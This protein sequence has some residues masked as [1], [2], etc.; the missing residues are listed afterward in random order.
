MHVIPKCVPSPF[1]LPK[2]LGAYLSILASW[3]CCHKYHQLGDLNNRNLLSH[4]SGVQKSKN[5][6]S[7]VTSFRGLWGQIIYISLFSL[8]LTSDTL[9]LVDG[10]L[11]TLS[12]LCVHLSL[13]KFPLFIRT[14][15]YW[16]KVQ[17]HNRTLTWSYAKN[18][19]PNKVT[20]T[21][22]GG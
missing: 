10:I 20:L 15:S 2:S 8:L 3:G 22:T 18:L 16:I 13:S 12:S 9:W 21:S 7:R 11:F 14:H 4:S 6:M 1:H 19:F 5:H 17:S